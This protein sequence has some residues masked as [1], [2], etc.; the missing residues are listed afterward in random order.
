MNGRSKWITVAC[1]CA[2]QC[3]GAHAQG[4]PVYDAQSVVQAI[5]TV[6]QLKQQVDQE[7]QIYQSTIGTR[8]FGALLSNPVV[9]NSLPSN[10][11]SVYAAIQNG[12]YAGL[13]GNAQALRSASQVYDCEDQTGVDQQVCRRMLNKPY[14]DKAFGLQAYQTELQELDQIQSLAQQINATQDPKGVAELQ[15]RI[16]TESTAVGNEMTKLQLFR[17]LAD[18]EDKLVAEQQSELVLSRAGK[19]KRLQDQMV[20]A[21][22]GN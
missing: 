22:F 10:W 4:I 11:Q 19:T 12:G 14:Q 8:G 20:P 13:T 9:A 5:A 17:M 3:A 21:S 1:V 6:G 2:T 16:Q 18:T 7:M 15:A